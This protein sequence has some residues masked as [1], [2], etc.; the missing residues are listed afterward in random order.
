MS[1]SPVL[2]LAGEEEK[3]PLPYFKNNKG[4]GKFYFFFT[5]R[6]FCLF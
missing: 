1:V 4:G 3:L 5:F 6:A 2:R